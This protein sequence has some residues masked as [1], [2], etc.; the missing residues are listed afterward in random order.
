MDTAELDQWEFTIT[1]APV[2]FPSHVKDRNLPASQCRART[3]VQR[4]YRLHPAA[5]KFMHFSH[6]RPILKALL[7]NAS[8][9]SRSERTPILQMHTIITL[10]SAI[11]HSAI[12]RCSGGTR[13]YPLE[14]A[15]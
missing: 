2:A 10:H 14:Y 1:N 3:A 15:L 9:V 7:W 6:C 11:C 4:P 13:I 12:Y 5:C 8:G